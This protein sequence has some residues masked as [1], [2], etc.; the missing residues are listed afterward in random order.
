MARPVKSA[1]EG[2]DGRHA[3]KKPRFFA[4]RLS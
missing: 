1:P 4:G 3:G 2:V